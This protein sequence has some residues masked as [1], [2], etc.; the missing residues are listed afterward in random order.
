MNNL[1][2]TL[3]N[4]TIRKYGFEHRNTLIVFRLTDLMRRV[5]RIEY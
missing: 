2:T 3:E 1:I 5:F 4:N